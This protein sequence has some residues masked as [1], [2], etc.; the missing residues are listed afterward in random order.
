MSL[1]SIDDLRL[2]RA[3]EAQSKASV[4]PL[5]VGLAANG[6]PVMRC[7]Y[8]G[9][10]CRGC[11]NWLGFDSRICAGGDGLVHDSRSCVAAAERELSAQAAVEEPTIGGQ[12]PTAADLLRA[13]GELARYVQLE[14]DF[15]LAEGGRM[16]DCILPRDCPHVLARFFQ[17]VAD[18]GSE[19][20]TIDALRCA[21]RTLM[22]RTRVG[23]D[24]LASADAQCAPTD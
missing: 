16:A 15:M 5:P 4:A 24:L 13:G 1:Q 12:P 2:S 19:G 23:V 14:I 18:G 22:V 11:A 8:A 20:E 9:M 6:Q 21:A 3:A 17:W 10:R 7:R